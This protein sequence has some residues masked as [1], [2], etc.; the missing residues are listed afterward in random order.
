MKM[1]FVISRNWGKGDNVLL[2]SNLTLLLL[3]VFNPSIMYNRNLYMP[4][5]KGG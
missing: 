1:F 2:S 3:S 5:S 4:V